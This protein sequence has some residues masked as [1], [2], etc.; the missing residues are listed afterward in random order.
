[1]NA[2]EALVGKL[3]PDGNRVCDGCADR[4]QLAAAPGVYHKYR[5]CP[6]CFKEV[7]PEASVVDE[8]RG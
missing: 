6:R 5:L 8:L 7:F 2:T 1:M 3:D 4:I